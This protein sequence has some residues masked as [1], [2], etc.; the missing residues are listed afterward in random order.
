MGWQLSLSVAHN[1]QK[2]VA[3]LMRW[4]ID[5]YRWTAG[6]Y[7][8]KATLLRE[9]ILFPFLSRSLPDFLA[10]S[11]SVRARA[12]FRA[13][14]AIVKLTAGHGQHNLVHFWWADFNKSLAHRAAL[15]DLNEAQLARMNWTRRKTFDFPSVDFQYSICDWLTL[16]EVPP[17]RP[18]T[19]SWGGCYG[20]KSWLC[21]RVRAAQGQ[22]VPVRSFVPPAS[23]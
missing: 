13:S 5:G 7:K 20:L 6:T 3:T 10:R 19:G 23:H 1:P 15:T 22:A 11:F 9:G 12:F 4:L 21:F 2:S 16:V 17:S 8:C 18:C 14:G